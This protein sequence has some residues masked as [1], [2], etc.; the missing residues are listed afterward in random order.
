MNPLKTK[1]NDVTDYFMSF[2]KMYPK[3][4]NKKK[5]SPYT[6][7]RVNFNEWNRV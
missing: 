4:Y 6:K 3:A 1:T 7:T 5:A 2:Q